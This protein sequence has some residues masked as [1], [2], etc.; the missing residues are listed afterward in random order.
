MA[1][2]YCPECETDIKL[3]KAPRKGQ[4]VNCWK[5][6]ADLEVVNLSPIELD[7]VYDDDNDVVFASDEGNSDLAE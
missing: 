5:C 1:V 6:G 2:G 3:G 7:W 4:R